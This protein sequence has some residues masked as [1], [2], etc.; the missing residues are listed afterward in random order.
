M[1]AFGLSV[2]IASILAVAAVWFQFR[3]RR[4]PPARFSPMGVEVGRHLA[5]AV[6]CAVIAG[7]LVSVWGTD[8]WTIMACA[9]VLWLAYG[10]FVGWRAWNVLRSAAES[11]QA[12]DG[13]R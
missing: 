6:L 4:S 9:V 2:S 8:D 3:A 7:L 13:G 5:V 12:R 10:S 1:R 11:G